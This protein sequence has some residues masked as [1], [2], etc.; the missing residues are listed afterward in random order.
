M[1]LTL[2]FLGTG[3]SS[4]VPMIGCTCPV[5]RSSDPRDKRTRASV[6][7]SYPDPS[8]PNT[9]PHH[10]LID[11]APELR[12]QLLPTA[13]QSLDAVFLTHAHADHIFGLDDLRRFNALM[14]RPIDIYADPATL[15]ILQSTFRY[16]FHPDANINRSFVPS[17]QLHALQPG[18]SLTLFGARW[19]A[20]ALW[21]GKLP[22]LGF[23][24]D[25]PGASLA[26]CTDASRI[27]PETYPLLQNLDVLV[28][29][30]LRPHPHPTHFTIDQAL[31]EILR[32]QPRRAYLTHLA[33]DLSHAQLSAQLPPHVHLPYDG[34]TVSWPD[35]TERPLSP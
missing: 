22:I 16:A 28:I 3:T 6:L 1:S 30:A 17:F 8:Q 34:L 33:H 20:L 35:L 9:S 19:T 27:P 12:L 32:I 25:L 23:R 14:H 15:D 2:T 13:I 29:D 18:Q 10:I 11:A 24:I 21:H 7:V 4:G 5:C 31:Q 26:Y